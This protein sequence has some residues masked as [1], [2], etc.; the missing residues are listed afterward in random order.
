MR[1]LYLLLF[2]LMI[3]KTGKGEYYEKEII[4]SVWPSGR[5]I[6]TEEEHE[7]SIKT[8]NFKFNLK[9]ACQL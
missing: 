2:S 8:G 6:K 3:I 7:D 1:L 5:V 4:F 9:V